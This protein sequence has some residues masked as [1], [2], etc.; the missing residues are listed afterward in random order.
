MA[1]TVCRRKPEVECRDCE[2]FGICQVAGLGSIDDSLLDDVVSRQCPVA[3]GETLLIPGTPF[4]GVFAVKS[5]AFRTTNSVG[6][7]DRVIGFHFLGELIGLETINGGQ[8]LYTVKALEDSSV[9][10]LDF[11]HLHRLGPRLVQ[12]QEQLIQAMSRRMRHD[13]QICTLLRAQNSERRLAAFLYSV[14]NRLDASRKPAAEFRL[15]MRREDIASYLGLAVE[16]ISRLLTQFNQRGIADL[17][18]RNARIL[19]FDAL[20]TLAGFNPPAKTASRG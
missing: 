13:Q 15:P 11:A 20:R 19:D 9:C 5:G 7:S 8:Y 3:K 16:T 4:R 10:E 14:A 17:R 6:Q 18:G 12:F 2:L 1:R